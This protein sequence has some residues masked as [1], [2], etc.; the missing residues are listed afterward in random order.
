MD[1]VAEA[2]PD[3]KSRKLPDAGYY[4][5]QHGSSAGGARISVVMDCGELGFR[6]IAAHGHADALSIVLRAFGRDVLTDSGTYDYFTYGPWRDY[7]R[8]TAAHNTLV[9][10]HQNQSE[11]LGSFLW[12]RRANAICTEWSP[13][14]DGGRIV[15]EHDGYTS[16]ADPVTHRRA[17]TLEGEQGVVVVEDE[18]VAR[19]S[20]DL[21]FHWHLAEHCKVTPT[22]EHEFTIDCGGGSV[23]VRFD[24]AL[25]VRMVCGSQDPP[26]GWVSRAYHHKA[27]TTTLVAEARST[28]TVRFRT[29]IRIVEG[30]GQAD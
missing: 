20:H 24:P 29:E 8:S 1:T 23:V 2:S 3:L 19:E 25:A 11:I 22:G 18:V 27:A 5:L 26:L 28:G 6:S 14:D 15:A 30:Q 17:V 9:V 16:L 13:A 21:A 7:F 10:D 12:G 4:L